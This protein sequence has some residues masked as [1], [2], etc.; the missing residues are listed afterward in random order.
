MIIDGDELW[1]GSYNLSDNAEHNTFENML[2]FKGA[3]FE[4]LIENYQ[5]NFLAVWNLNR[6]NE[7][8]ETIFHQVTRDDVI[9]L[10]FSPMSLTWSEIQYLKE[11][12]LD[13]CPAVANPNQEN[14]DED[15]QGDACDPDDD[16]DGALD[17]EDC[18]PFDASIHP[19]AV[20]ECDNEDND[21]DDTVDQFDVPCSSSCED[22]V[23]TCVAGALIELRG[24]HLEFD[25]CAMAAGVDNFS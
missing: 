18:K 2:Y 17:D 11:T 19:D 23:A 10:V 7:T 22:G 12:I 3:D 5:N 20:E 14:F 15:T 21:C 16:N 25:R 9:P 24:D 1:T 4:G 13:N 8:Y 6:E